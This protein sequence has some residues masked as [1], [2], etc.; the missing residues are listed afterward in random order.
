MLR[1]SYVRGTLAPSIRLA[2][3]LDLGRRALSGIRQRPKKKKKGP[4]MTKK[5]RRKDLLSGMVGRFAQRM[6]GEKMEFAKFVRSR[7]VANVKRHETE[8]ERARMKMKFTKEQ[9][10]K[11]LM[12]TVSTKATKVSPKPKTMIQTLEMT[13]PK[14]AEID[15]LEQQ[16][17]DPSVKMFRSLLDLNR[18]RGKIH[19]MM[20]EAPSSVFLWPDRFRQGFDKS[21]LDKLNADKDESSFL[22]S[23]YGFQNA[24]QSE[25]GR[26]VI[27]QMIQVFQRKNADTGSSEVQ[28]N[29]SF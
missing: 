26:Q 19:R 10:D 4:P 24:S 15:E 1:V 21:M 7:S 2:R 5:E 28:S 20:K 27:K 25:I 12:M 17:L 22:K 13:T 3:P 18:A 6:G 16:T 8:V 14:S 9:F 23:I 11:K 29:S